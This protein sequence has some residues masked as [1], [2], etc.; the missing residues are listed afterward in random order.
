MLLTA[1]GDANS[2]RM[3]A[4]YDSVCFFFHRV[5][6]TDSRTDE[7]LQLIEIF[8]VVEYIYKTVTFLYGKA[9]A[10]LKIEALRAT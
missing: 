9:R 8:D 1:R 6:V 5:A 10:T 7:I 2:T 3:S 4:V